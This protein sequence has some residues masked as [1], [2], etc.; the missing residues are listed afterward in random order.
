M[1]FKWKPKTEMDF[2]CL[3]ESGHAVVSTAA[4]CAVH[5]VIVKQEGEIRIGLTDYQLPTRLSFAPARA[6]EIGILFGGKGMP[7]RS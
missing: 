6:M 2:A 3:H 7:G 1:G 4:G 5:R